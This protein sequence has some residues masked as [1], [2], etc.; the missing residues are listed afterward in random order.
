MRRAALSTDSTA[1]S[2][3]SPTLNR[4]GRCSE[5]SRD[6]SERLMKV[7]MSVSAILTSMPLSWT[8]STSQVTWLPFLSLPIDSIGSPP[9]C[10]MPRLMRS[11][12]ASTSSTT[13]LTMSPFL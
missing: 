12:C 11:F 9:T 2:T 3:L 4:S 1:A 8:A 7:V 10:L 5:R 13:A 6:R